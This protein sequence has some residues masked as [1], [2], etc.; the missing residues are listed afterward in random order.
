[1]GRQLAASIRQTD[2]VELIYLEKYPS[3][4]RGRGLV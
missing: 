4:Q 3:R 2:E 1:M